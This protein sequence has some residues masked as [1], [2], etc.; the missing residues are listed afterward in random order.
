[1]EYTGAWAVAELRP[2]PEGDCEDAPGQPRRADT[3]AAAHARKLLLPQE[4]VDKLH[5]LPQALHSRVRNSAGTLLL[6]F[7]VLQADK[8][9]HPG[10]GGEPAPGLPAPL[11]GAGTWS[12][13]AEPREHR[14]PNRLGS[15]AHGLLGR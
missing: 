11:P 8:M 12:C 6:G 9:L 2:H 1:M 10:A 13:P 5:F 3:G 15:T 14:P 4:K 7:G